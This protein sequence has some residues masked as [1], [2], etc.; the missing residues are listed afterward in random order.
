MFEAVGLA[1]H[2]AAQAFLQERSDAIFTL[3]ANW[4]TAG[5]SWAWMKRA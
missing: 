1:M 4:T 5:S 2:D 3:S